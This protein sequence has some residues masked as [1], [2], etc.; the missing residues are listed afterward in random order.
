M[1]HYEKVADYEELHE[2]IK[3]YTPEP[4]AGGAS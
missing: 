3:D 4:N 1:A 2:F